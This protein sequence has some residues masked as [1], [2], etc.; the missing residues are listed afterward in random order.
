LYHDGAIDSQPVAHIEKGVP[1]M[2]KEKEEEEEKK[3]E[4]LR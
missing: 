1:N 2:D 4:I 3:E